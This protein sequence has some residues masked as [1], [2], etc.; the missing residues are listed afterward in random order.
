MRI[1]TALVLLFDLFI[2]AGS[3]TAHYTD[4]GAVPFEAVEI[5]YW[6]PGYFS[7]FSYCREYWS[8]L[9]LFIVTGVFYFLLLLGYKTR[10]FTF[11]SWVMLVSLQ[12]RN[13]LIL[14]GGDDALRLLLFWGIFLPW[15]NFYSLDKK[16]TR[17][18][19]NAVRYFSAASV[20][21][22]LL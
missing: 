11:L 4:A 19:D 2:R 13:T 15:G 18:N 10:L 20:G 1:L 6:Q 3:L 21:Y 17:V 12:N 5:V 7:L 9:L 16:T 22:V 8:V 14:Q